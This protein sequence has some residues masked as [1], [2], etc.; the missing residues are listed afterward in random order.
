MWLLRAKRWETKTLVI[1]LQERGVSRPEEQSINT[2]IYLVR[3]VAYLYGT[4]V[5]LEWFLIRSVN[6]LQI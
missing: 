4:L 2:A 1:E 6:T 5:Q 3:S